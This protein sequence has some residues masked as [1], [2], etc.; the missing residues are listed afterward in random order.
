[1]AFCVEPS[2]ADQPFAGKRQKQIPRSSLLNGL[3]V[4]FCQGHLRRG[5]RQGDREVSESELPPDEQLSLGRKAK[6][7]WR[8]TP[9]LPIE[10]FLDLC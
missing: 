3:V 5:H 4:M 6:R 8:L 9:R 7:D 1:M 2:N 10:E